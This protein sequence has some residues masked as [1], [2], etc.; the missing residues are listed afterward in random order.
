MTSSLY[1][2]SLPS[3]SLHLSFLLKFLNFADLIQIQTR[4]LVF[5]PFHPLL[6]YAPC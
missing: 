2:L 1:F 3:L 5:S 6:H 4:P